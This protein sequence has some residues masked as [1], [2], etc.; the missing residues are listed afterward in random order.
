MFTIN[1]NFEKEEKKRDVI[2]ITTYALDILHSIKCIV[3]K[4]C[5]INLKYVLEPISMCVVIHTIH[6]YKMIFNE[7][8][9]LKF[10]YKWNCKHSEFS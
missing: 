5:A 4:E 1:S 9:H 7:W 8:D 3:W 6:T 10:Y 2:A